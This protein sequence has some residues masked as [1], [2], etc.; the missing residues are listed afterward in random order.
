MQPCNATFNHCGALFY[1]WILAAHLRAR[2]HLVALCVY[3]QFLTQL[4]DC[5]RQVRDDDDDDDCADEDGRGNWLVR[6]L[7]R[8]THTQIR[9]NV[10]CARLI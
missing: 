6:C 1:N 3:D 4:N 8:A 2:V 5:A 9:P 7:R 10:C